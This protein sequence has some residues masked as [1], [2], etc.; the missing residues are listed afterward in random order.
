MKSYLISTRASAGYEQ[1]ARYF[2]E[3]VRH[4]KQA[5]LAEQVQ[6]LLHS[7]FAQQLTHLRSS[8]LR[9]L[10]ADM[11]GRDPSETFAASAAR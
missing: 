2:E 6:Q 10:N 7:A 8:T 5:E 4:A 1:E 3:G 11:V 9:H